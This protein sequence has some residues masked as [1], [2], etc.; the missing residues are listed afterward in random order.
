MK[1]GKSTVITTI[2]FIVVL[3]IIDAFLLVILF[4]STKKGLKNRGYDL[5]HEDIISSSSVNDSW[6]NN[7]YSLSG[8]YVSDI[9]THKKILLDSL[10]S[11]SPLPLFVCRINQFDCETCTTY[12]LQKALE[13][14]QKYSDRYSFVVLGAYETDLALS[15]VRNNNSD[16]TNYYNIQHIDIPIDDHGNP[17]FFIVDKSLQIRDVFTPDRNT[18][19][20]TDRYEKLVLEGKAAIR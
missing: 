15:I 6:Q 1:I 3:M 5:S 9:L 20:L 13:L 18:K 2:L 12:L 4:G 10:V 14:K 7:G 16:D 17:Y 19:N 11:E 8:I